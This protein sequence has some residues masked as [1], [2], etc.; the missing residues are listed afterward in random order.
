MAHLACFFKQPIGVPEHDLH[1]QWHA[2]VEY[3]EQ[4]RR[5]ARR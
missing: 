5:P 2:L 1:R 4:V 3:L